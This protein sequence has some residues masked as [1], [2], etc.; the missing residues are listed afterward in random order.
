MKKLLST[1][2]VAKLVGVAPASVSNWID[3]D[4]LKAG[5]TPGGHRRIE[6]KDLIEFLRKQNLPIPKQLSVWTARILVVDDE[7]NTVKWI[8]DELQADRPD[9]QVLEA[10][11]GFAA[12]EII[13]FERPDVVI[14]DLK[15]PGLDGFEVCRRVKSRDDGHAI[16]IIAMTAYHSP[17]AEQRILEAGARVCL[18]KPIAWEV[19]LKEI[20]AALA[21]RG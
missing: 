5:R 13:G 9:F 6:A 16:A 12:G 14:L 1:S 15:M 8:A 3:Q 2:S 19:L 17:A 21:D 4:H 18:P 20:D 11:D 10:Y 7:P